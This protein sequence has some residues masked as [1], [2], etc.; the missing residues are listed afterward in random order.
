MKMT[1]L[2]LQNNKKEVWLEKQPIEGRWGGLWMF[3]FWMHKEEMTEKLVASC[4]R[5]VLF[6]TVPHAFTKYRITLEVFG[7]ICKR[8]TPLKGRCGRWFSIAK[9]TRTAG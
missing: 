7:S 2:V 9:L 8:G 4:S 3:P 1:A 6:M 5:P